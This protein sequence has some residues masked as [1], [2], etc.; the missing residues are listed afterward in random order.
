MTF[1]STA[2]FAIMIVVTSCATNAEPGFQDWSR[3]KL[4]TMIAI[5]FLIPTNAHVQVDKMS[6]LSE[7]FATRSA[8]CQMHLLNQSASDKELRVIW[9]LWG[10]GDGENKEAVIRKFGQ[11]NYSSAIGQYVSAQLVCSRESQQLMTDILREVEKREVAS[12]KS[13]RRFNTLVAE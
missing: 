5:D 2:C 7:M 1:R 8:R 9:Y 3:Q 11:T 4:L 13:I 6:H 12:E 10:Y